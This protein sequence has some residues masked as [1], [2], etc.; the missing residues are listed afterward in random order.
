[1]ITSF[2]NTLDYSQL[3]CNDYNKILIWYLLISIYR[4]HLP[5]YKCHYHGV[6]AQKY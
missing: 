2:G 4:D 3:L 1:M 5:K 6:I